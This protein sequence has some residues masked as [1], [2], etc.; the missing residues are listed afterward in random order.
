MI[1]STVIFLTI[2]FT[3]KRTSIDVSSKEMLFILKLWGGACYILLGFLGYHKMARTY[4]IDGGKTIRYTSCT[5][6]NSVVY[7]ICTSRKQ[8]DAWTWK[9]NWKL[10]TNAQSSIYFLCTFMQG[11]KRQVWEQKTVSHINHKQKSYNLKFW[12]QS[13]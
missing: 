10:L 3:K 1:C 8:L 13:W 7:S 9:S 4:E 2:F 5:V 11:R 12:T 6:R